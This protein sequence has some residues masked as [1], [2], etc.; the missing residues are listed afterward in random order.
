VEI[1]QLRSVEAVVRHRHFTRAAEE[2]HL[3][4]SALS[5]QIRRLE[6]ELG[7][8]LFERTSRRVSPTE[9]GEAIAARARRVLAEVD[10]AR[11]EVDEL[12]GV[13]RGRIWIGPLV[14]AGDV[15]VPG[16]LARFSQAHP[17]V[18]VGLREGIAADMLRL[19]A[20]DELDAAFCL[21]AGEVPD[22]FAV[23][24]LGEDEAVAAFAPERAPTADHVTVADLDRRPIIGP[25]QGSAIT[26]AVQERFADAGERL[27]LALGSGD[28]FL[29]RSLAARGFATAIL[30]R[31]LTALEGPPLELRSLEPAVHLPVALVWRRGRNAPPAARTFIEFVR[32]DRGVSRPAS[33]SASR[34]S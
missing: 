3:A 26:S 16:L 34:A 25:R 9:A 17:G 2:L 33:T 18:D 5:Y 8:P 29:L 10:A 11:E 28:P 19:V 6:Q 22:E 15:D 32:S 14:P 12:R 23:E 13:L 24:R 4:Q 27:R 21:L 30:P 1:R 20:A 7:T 31:S